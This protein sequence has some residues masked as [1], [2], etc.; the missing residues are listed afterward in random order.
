MQLYAGRL[1][2]SGGDSVWL[3]PAGRLA[4]LEANR[5]RTASGDC[6]WLGDRFA[7]PSSVRAHRC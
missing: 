1:G 7:R 5:R 6:E 3:R 4:D 2:L